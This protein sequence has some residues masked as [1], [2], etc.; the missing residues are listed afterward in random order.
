V[1]RP[2]GLWQLKND[3]EDH[4]PKGD[5]QK[6]VHE[7]NQVLPTPMDTGGGTIDEKMRVLHEDKCR[8]PL[9]SISRVPRNPSPL[10]VHG[11]QCADPLQMSSPCLGPK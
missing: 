7:T 9:V 11:P 3:P 10:N 2:V 4:P 5:A 1:K 6:E 8:N